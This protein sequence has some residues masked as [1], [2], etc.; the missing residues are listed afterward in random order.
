[1][2]F[3]NGHKGTKKFSY[4]QIKRYAR[5]IFLLKV[6]I[7]THFFKIYTHV[8]AKKAVILHPINYAHLKSY[9]YEKHF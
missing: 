8:C 7:F 6:S 3:K 5:E 2:Y 9:K 4:T 1:M